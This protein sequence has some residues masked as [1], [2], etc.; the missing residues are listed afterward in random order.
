MFVCVGLCVF[1]RRGQWEWQV[2]KTVTASALYI[3]S[4]S[5]LKLSPT[6][7]AV[8]QSQHNFAGRTKTRRRDWLVSHFQRLQICASFHFFFSVG[9]GDS[10]V[11]GATAHRRHSRSGGGAEAKVETDRRPID[12]C[13]RLAWSLHSSAGA[14]RWILL[15]FSWQLPCTDSPT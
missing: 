12:W 1:L 15:T 4:P 11:R 13:T 8:V 5:S 10:K 14:R 9:F 3:A 7:K 2:C 6:E